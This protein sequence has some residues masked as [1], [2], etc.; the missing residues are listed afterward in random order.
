MKG[1]PKATFTC[2]WIKMDDVLEDKC[3]ADDIESFMKVENL[4][5]LF[6]YRCNKM[7]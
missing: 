5:A 1:K 2:K 6:E 4:E 3:K 7:L